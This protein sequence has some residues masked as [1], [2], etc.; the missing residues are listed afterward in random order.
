MLEVYAA[1][2]YVPGVRSSSASHG[3]VLLQ[4][5]PISKGKH[6]TA[7]GL[8]SHERS[9]AVGHYRPSPVF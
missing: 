6:E 4:K 9:V 1:Y 8:H 2:K 5:T 3:K 7:L